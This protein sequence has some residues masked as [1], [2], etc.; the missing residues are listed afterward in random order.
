MSQPGRFKR[1]ASE[2]AVIVVSILLAFWIDAWWDRRQARTA[3]AAVL[4]SIRSEVEANRLELDLQE[5]RNAN[6]FDRIDRFLGATPDDL[7]AL[8]PDSVVPWLSAMITTWTYDGDDSAAG[9]FL[10]SST[11][12]TEYGRAVRGALARWVRIMD[13]T[14]EEKATLWDGGAEL[15]RI[16]ARYAVPVAS[17]GLEGLQLMTAQRGSDLLVRLRQ[18]EDWIAALLHK[19]HYQNVYALELGDASAVLDSL[20]AVVAG[21]SRHGNARVDP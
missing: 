9:L 1:L 18:D 6:Q 20:G 8:P 13:D 15:A 3:E 21:A 14:E 16:L 10:G 2:G 12:V 7:R 19:A 11:P 4:E 17:E 5:S